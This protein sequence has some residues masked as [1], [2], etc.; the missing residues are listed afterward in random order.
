MKKSLIEMIYENEMPKERKD[1]K[2]LL[3]I[4]YEYAEQKEKVSE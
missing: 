4:V 1:K 2:S 3:E